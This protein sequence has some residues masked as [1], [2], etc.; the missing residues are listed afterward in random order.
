MVTHKFRTR[1]GRS[2]SFSKC[3]CFG[4]CAANAHV[5]IIRRPTHL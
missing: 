1:T 4:V 2:L 5:L 3:H